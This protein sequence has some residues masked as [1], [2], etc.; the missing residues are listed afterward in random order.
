MERR[1]KRER[2]IRKRNRES[3]WK[4]E[5]IQKVRGKVVDKV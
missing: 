4:G 2:T 1:S 3:V 5:V